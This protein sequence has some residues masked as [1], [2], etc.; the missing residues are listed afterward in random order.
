MKKVRF[1][2]MK[3]ALG[4]FITSAIAL[5]SCS[6]EL[7]VNDDPNNPVDVPASSLTT[8]SEVNLAYILGGD[9][10]RM[11]A[12]VIQHYAGHRNQ[13][14]EYGQYRITSSTTDNLW[15]NLYDVMM[16]MRAVQT[17][18]EAS[19]DKIYLGIAQI[20][21]AYTM[22][23]TTDMFGD[24]PYSEA[25]QGTQNVNPAYDT[26]ESIYPKLISL[27]DKGIINVKSNEGLKPSTADVIYGG[28]VVKW[29]AFGNS[30]K[31]RL[32]NHLSKKN[33]SAAKTFLDTNPLLITSSANNAKV[34]FGTSAANA[35]PIYQFDVLSGRKDNAVCNVLVD[36]MKSLNDPRIP[37]YF[38][39]VLNNTSGLAGQYLGN[40]PGG[41]D[42]DSGESK[43]SRVGSAYG[44]TDSPVILMSA[45]EVEF[46]KAEIYQRAGDNASAK[47]AYEKAI[48]EDFA[49]LGVSGI[50]TYLANANVVFDNTLKRIVEQKWITMYQSSFEAW[51]DWRRTGFPALTS[52]TVNRTGGVIPRR[53]PYP[54]TEVNLNGAQLASGPGIPVPYEGLKTPVWW[55]E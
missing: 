22:S 49:Y 44:A 11:S 4:G 3:F 2:I 36:K 29:E 28:D 30:L 45:A 40:I 55:D 21:E 8:S 33:P 37:V 25:F 17:K 10:T 15:S 16:D 6:Q 24:V 47:I 41:E 35:N 19:G 26:Q 48:T 39:K 5:N 32:Y 1:N 14:L 27:I 52:A 54:Q 46:I 51:V 12:N 23:I 34:A 42:D 53:L 9:A 31:L 38:N 7:D 18:A 13:P 43:F 20:L 50:T